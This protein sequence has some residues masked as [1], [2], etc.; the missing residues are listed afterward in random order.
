Y[1]S[2]YDQYGRFYSQTLNLS[3]LDVVAPTLISST[4]SDNSV[5]VQ[6]NSNLILN[7]SEKVRAGTGNIIITDGT[8][9]RIVDVTDSTQVTFSGKTV[10]INPTDDLQAGHHYYIEMASGVIKDKSGNVFAG[11][12]DATTLDFTTT[13]AIAPTLTSFSGTVATTAEDT[14]ATITFANLQS[15]G[16]EA[17]IDGAVTAFVVKALSTGTLKIGADAATATAWNATTNNTIDAIHLAYW[18]PVANANGSLNAFTVVAKDNGGLES[19][20]PVQATIN[21]TAVNDAPTLTSFSG[22]VAT[23]AEDIQAT[24]TFANLQSQGDEADIDGSVTAF[25]VKAVST[26][27]LKIGV[28]AAT[29]TVWNATTNNTIDATHLAYW[30]PVA[31]A[32]GSLNAF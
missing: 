27:T 20:T 14:Q 30:T 9:R 13:A 19:A 17:D 31:N 2:C 12:T 18:T 1:F 21:V 29:A 24:I 8:D 5:G 32:N 26:G 22:T 23:T 7:F 10:T 15:Q 28:D 25:V 6:V 3:Y 4:P 11:I 16:D